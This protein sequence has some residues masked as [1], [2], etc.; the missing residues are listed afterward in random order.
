MMNS[1]KSQDGRLIKHAK[2]SLTAMELEQAKYATDM[3]QVL[4]VNM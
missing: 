1:T 3:S 2:L 4:T